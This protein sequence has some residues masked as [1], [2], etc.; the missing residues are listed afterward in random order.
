M[1]WIKISERES[2]LISKKVSLFSFRKLGR[3]LSIYKGAASWENGW[4]RWDWES[5]DCYSIRLEDGV[6]YIWK[7]NNPQEYNFLDNFYK[8]YWREERLKYILRF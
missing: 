2:E 7:G 1:E 6:H 3:V 4:S 8:A 5:A